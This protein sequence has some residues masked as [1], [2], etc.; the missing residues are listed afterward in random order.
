VIDWTMCTIIMEYE[1]LLIVNLLHIYIVYYCEYW[2]LTVCHYQ[3]TESEE[4][5]Q[6]VLNHDIYLAFLG[7]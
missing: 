4:W 1:F 5:E 3:I 2:L 6:P 7:C